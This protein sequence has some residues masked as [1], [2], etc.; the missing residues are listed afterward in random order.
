[1]K[2][3]NRLKRKYKLWRMTQ[4]IGIRPQVLL[5]K[6]IQCWYKS[7]RTQ[8]KHYLVFDYRGRV[9]IINT[10]MLEKYKKNRLLNRNWSKD[11]LYETK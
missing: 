9:V 10:L 8:Q 4:R 3:I 11:I 1:M 2:L 7:Y 6:K 5:I